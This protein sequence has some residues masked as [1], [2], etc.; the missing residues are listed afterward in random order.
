MSSNWDILVAGGG[1]SGLIATAAFGRLGANVLCTDI[2]LRES[3]TAFD[4]R[5]TAFFGPS[6][7]VL[8]AAGIWDSLQD[9]ATP[10]SVMRI[11]ET[12][13]FANQPTRVF[14]FRSDMIDE[15][16]FG[17]SIANHR[18]ETALRTICEQLPNVQIVA[19]TAVKSALPRLNEIIVVLSDGRSCKAKLLV[20]ADGRESKVRQGAGIGVRRLSFGQ[21]SLSFDVFLDA[22][23]NNVTLEIHASGGPFTLV[24]IDDINNQ[25][26]AAVVW[27]E[28]AVKAEK[29]AALSASEF[30]ASMNER[31]SGLFGRLELVGRVQSWPALS[32]IA[33]RL[34]GARLALIGEAAHVLPP[35][36]AQGLNMT[37]A[38]IKAF[39]DL[40]QKFPGDFGSRDWLASYERAR[41]SQMAARVLGVTALNRASLAEERIPTMLRRYGLSMIHEFPPLRNRLMHAGMGKNL[42]FLMQQRV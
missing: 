29:L 2:R 13:N 8:K 34:T 15:L 40:A 19:G 1:L 11:A 35:I 30:E 28:E 18:V 27:M 3:K 32:Q 36:G 5:T 33:N 4:N 39:L 31:S 42:P 12:G 23:H 37:L 10:L 6:M 41:F 22:P 21:T 20:A 26:A 9:A 17:Y 7:L 24:P 38:D 16:V 14:E 25:A